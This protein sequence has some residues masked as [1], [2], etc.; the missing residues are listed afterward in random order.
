MRIEG[1]MSNSVSC[2]L[3]CLI[4]KKRMY[5]SKIVD[6]TGSNQKSLFNVVNN[7]E[8]K[9]LPEHTDPVK[10]ANEFNNYYIKKMDDIRKTAFLTI[11]KI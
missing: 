4:A 5:Y 10:L 6:D 3:I 1:L 7:L 9:S 8:A 2:V 11:P